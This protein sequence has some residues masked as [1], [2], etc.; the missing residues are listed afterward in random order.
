MIDD[1]RFANTNYAGNGISTDLN[2]NEW[3]ARSGNGSVTHNGGKL[4]VAIENNIYHLIDLSTLENDPGEETTFH[5]SFDVE[6]LSGDVAVFAFAGG[7]LAYNG[8]SDGRIFYRMHGNPPV[9]S[10]ANGA[11]TTQVVDGATTT[12]TSTGR[13]STAV[14]LN[15]VGT[16]G[17]YLLIGFTNDGES[18]TIDNLSIELPSEFADVVSKSVGDD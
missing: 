13:F 11:T 12:I 6:S 17:D 4:D 7:G 10:V 1:W 14:T 15:D 9:F 2:Q 8:N 16:A 3:I 18:L 5:L